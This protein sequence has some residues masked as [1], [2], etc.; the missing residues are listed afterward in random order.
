M[1]ERT[2][3]VWELRVYLGRHPVTGKRTDASRTFRGGERAAGKALAQLVT[4]V[5]E[6]RAAAFGD[7]RADGASRTPSGSNS[8][9]ATRRRR[10]AGRR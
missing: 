2:P 6:L 7:H 8:S 9:A 1:R 10:R 3:G 5:D 4:E